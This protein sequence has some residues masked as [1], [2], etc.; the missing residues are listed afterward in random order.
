MKKNNFFNFLKIFFSRDSFI[1]I[2]SPL[3]LINFIEYKKKKFIKSSFPILVGYAVDESINQIP[4]I[5]NKYLRS[6]EI[7]FL[8]K[9]FSVKVFHIILYIRKK[10]SKFKFC[11]IGDFNYYLFKEFYKYSNEN[12]I[13]DDGTGTLSFKKFPS[14]NNT[15]L[16]TIFKKL[17][18][19]KKIRILSNDYDQLKLLK[20]KK[21]KI[22]KKKLYI[23][24]S[25]S[26][27]RDFIQLKEFNLII[28]SILNKFK[29]RKI[30]YIP[31]RYENGFKNLK[32]Y[33]N[34]NLIKLKIPIEL[35]LIKKKEIPYVIIGF[36]STALFNL[37]KIYKNNVKIYNIKHKIDFLKDNEIK[38]RFKKIIEQLNFHKIKN[39]KF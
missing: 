32:N 22:N 20:I 1:L 13:L 28:N 39:I 38:L 4:L 17:K 24:G 11:I 6:N 9:L 19:K 18:L 8:K 2:N 7:F 31:H 21:Q 30:Y 33:K 12:V 35:V 5:N 37:N 29:D 10:L 14:F 27:E 36:Y 26:I 23:I 3:Q 25:A 34:I 16:F 15:T